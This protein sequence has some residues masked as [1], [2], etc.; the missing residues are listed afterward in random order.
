MSKWLTTGEMIDRLKVGEVAECVE[1]KN[2][3]AKVQYVKQREGLYFLQVTDSQTG[4]EKIFVIR[5]YH[6]KSR[7][8]IH[9]NYVTFEEAIRALKEGKKIYFHRDEDSELIIDKEEIIQNTLIGYRTFDELANGKWSI[10]D[11]AE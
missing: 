5:N 8:I 2:K 1:G 6:K 9:K 11:D 10:E 3:G 7:W 4:E